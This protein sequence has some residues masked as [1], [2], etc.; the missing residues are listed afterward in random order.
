MPKVPPLSTIIK[1]LLNLKKKELRVKEISLGY[2]VYVN[3]L[4]AFGQLGAGSMCIPM[5]EKQDLIQPLICSHLP[6]V[7]YFL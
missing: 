3:F 1:K 2:I 7:W 5:S 4:R 6:K